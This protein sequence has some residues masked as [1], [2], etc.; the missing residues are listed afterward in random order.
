MDNFI[1][2]VVEWFLGEL[3]AILI[4]IVEFL[5]AGPPSLL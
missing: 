5:F 3:S 1:S 2:A 4:S